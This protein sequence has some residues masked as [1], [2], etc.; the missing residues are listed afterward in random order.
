ML[1]WAREGRCLER[2]IAVS[3][4]NDYCARCDSNISQLPLAAQCDCASPFYASNTAGMQGKEP[5]LMGQRNDFDAV[6]CA[7]SV[8]GIWPTSG[9]LRGSL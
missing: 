6:G 8:V 5:A 1:D 4:E 2:Q 7:R 3:V 9:S